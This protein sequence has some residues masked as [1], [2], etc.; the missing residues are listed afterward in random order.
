MSDVPPSVNYRKEIVVKS[1]R[2]KKLALRFGRALGIKF[3]SS[4]AKTCKVESFV[5]AKIVYSKWVISFPV[6]QRLYLMFKA[7]LYF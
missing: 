7:L 6:F 4:R 3:Q 1:L 2:N 5:F